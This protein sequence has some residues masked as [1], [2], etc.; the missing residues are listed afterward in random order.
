[1]NT[2]STTAV[3]TARLGFTV[4]DVLLCLLPIVAFVAILSLV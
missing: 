3:S 1:M 2:Y 4:R